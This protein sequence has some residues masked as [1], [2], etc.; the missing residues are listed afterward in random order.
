M[1]AAGTS[2]QLLVDINKV[3]A[4][5]SNRPLIEQQ[6]K[7]LRDNYEEFG[8]T[9][10][11]HPISCIC[12]RADKDAVMAGHHELLTLLVSDFNIVLLSM[13]RRAKHGHVL[14]WNSFH[15]LIFSTELWGT[16]GVGM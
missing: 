1:E 5:E 4:D 7:E 3:Q 6:V 9:A 10:V 15:S 14:H 2:F 8:C 11:A 12:S 16:F 13:W